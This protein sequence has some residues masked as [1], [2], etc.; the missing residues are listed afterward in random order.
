MELVGFRGSRL[1]CGYHTGTIS[2][3]ILAE[4]NRAIHK[5]PTTPKKAILLRHAGTT[6][7]IAADSHIN[8]KRKLKKRPPNKAAKVDEILR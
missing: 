1:C 6:G 3:Q 5:I 2:Q 8:D 7:V 4:G